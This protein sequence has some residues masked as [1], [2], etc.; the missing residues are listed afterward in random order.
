MEIVVLK[1]KPF[2]ADYIRHKFGTRIRITAKGHEILHLRS[3]IMTGTYKQ[4]R[5]LML[6]KY[7]D[8]VEIEFPNLFIWK[9]GKVGIPHT[10]VVDFN[11]FMRDAIAA[12]MN[13]WLDAVHQN[14]NHNE[15]DLIVNYLTQVARID[16]ENINLDTWKKIRQ[17]YK[18][19]QNEG[20]LRKKLAG[21]FVPEM[22]NLSFNHAKA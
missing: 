13:H 19:E 2:I 6:K 16:I 3:L 18:I 1:C 14:V 17:R 20:P 5:Y 21:Q 15:N 11:S 4:T 10:A 7:S 9:S 22:G 8:S 12:N